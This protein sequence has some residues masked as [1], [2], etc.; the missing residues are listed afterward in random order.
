MG[1]DIS[2]FIPAYNEEENIRQ[3]LDDLLAVLREV[4]NRYEVIVVLYGGSTDATA[5][6]VRI[7]S[8]RDPAVKLVIQPADQ[9]GYGVALKLGIEN[10]THGLIFYTDADNQYDVREIGRLLEKMGEYDIA[11]GRRDKRRDP[12]MRLLTAAIYNRLVN[13][14]FPTGVQDIDSAFKLYKKSLLE[15]IQIH[16][17]TGLADA[18]ILAKA[19][20]I[21][22]R[23]VEVPIAHFPRVSGRPAFESRLIAGLGLVKPSVVINVVREMVQ[24]RR[25]LRFL[26]NGS[27]NSLL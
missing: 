4:A 17:K 19:R 1:F 26:R 8:K 13:S 3:V 14:L 5:D 10:S 9:K 12:P 25:E 27:G 24:L 23:I 6:I 21:G 18:E 2:A 15:K 20:R 22:A 16:C 7:F 11:S